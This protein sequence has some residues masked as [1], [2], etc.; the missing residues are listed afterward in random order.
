MSPIAKLFTVLNVVLAA[1]FLGFAARALQTESSFKQLYDD[2]VKAHK[3]DSDSSK[4]DHQALAAHKAEIEKARDAMQGERDSARAE[5]ERL[6]GQV[7]DQ[8][9]ANT[10]MRGSVDKIAKSIDDVM[11]GNKALSDARDNGC[12][13]RTQWRGR[14]VGQIGRGK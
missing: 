14:S 1:V 7:A 12:V 2:E 13:V 6:K 5:I 10:E 3:A 8:E 11:A 9:R 4:S